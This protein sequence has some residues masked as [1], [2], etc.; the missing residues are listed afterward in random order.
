MKVF[1][2]E[3]TFEGLL[4]AIYDAY[5][6]PIKPDIIYSK[7]VYEENLID[8]VIIINSDEAK[9]QKVYSAIINK[10]SKSVL[11]KIYY[12]FLSETKESSNM[13]YNYV[14]MG[15]KLG[16]DVELYKNNDIVLYM[17]KTSKR[18]HDEYHRFTGFVRFKEINNILYSSISP[19]FNILPMLADHFKNRLSNEYFIIH[20]IKRDIALVYNKEYYYL[21]NL[22][23]TQ[24][25][26]LINTP[27]EGEYENL[28]KQYFE[29]VN[30]EERKNP[31]LQKRMMPR[32]YWGNMTEMKNN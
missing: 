24:K 6:S 27:D 13:I 30:I 9:F 7:L 17:D 8:D 14:R 2:H 4:S 5:Y 31:R 23:E 21:T 3:P 10:I 12:V 11:N 18:V 16:K 15:F 32:R 25:D 29:S 28:W 22:S 1:I 19:V 26:I 20:D